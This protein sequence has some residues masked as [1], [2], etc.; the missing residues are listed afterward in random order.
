MRSSAGEHLVHTDE[1]ASDE[2]TPCLEASGANEPGT[3]SSAGEHALHTGGVVGSIP[4]ASTIPHP[5]VSGVYFLFKDREL[6]YTGKSQDV[7]GRINAH[8]TNGRPFDYALVGA[9]PLHDAGWVEAALIR[10]F[11]PKENKVGKGKATQPDV[12]KP[13][14]PTGLLRA[15]ERGIIPLAPK[16]A[17]DAL[18]SDPDMIIPLSKAQAYAKNFGLVS[19]VKPAVEDGTIP[20]YLNGRSRMMRV[21][22]VKTW[23]K[24][25]VRL[26][27]RP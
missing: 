17:R 16:P 5:V 13:R 3:R 15:R 11:Q 1:V 19:A 25:N 23:C 6:T 2:S 9:C 10:S 26:K 12:S 27:K 14:V 24:E 8:R 7:Y 20:S 4:T 21:G 22:D 18:P